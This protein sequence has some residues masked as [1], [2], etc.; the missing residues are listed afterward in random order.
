MIH[1]ALLTDFYA[2]TMAQGYWKNN[3]NKRA[4]FEVFFRRQPFGGGFS[5][6]AGLGPL[7]DTIRDF[8]FSDDDLAYLESLKFFEKPFLNYLRDFHFTGSLWAMDEGTV[9]FPQEPLI[10][11]SGNL[12]ECQIA[13]GMLLNIINF[14]S[15]IATKT[16]R[17]WLA[18]GKGSVM[19]FGLRRAQGP[20]G[21]MSASR[22]AFIGGAAGTS[23]VLAG[24]EY[25]IPVLGTMAHSWIM[26]YPSEEEAFQAYADIYPEF[27][28]FLI[29][30]YDTLKSGT[31][32]AIKV[33][34]RV[35]E[36]GKNFGVRLD[37]GDMHYLSVQVRKLLD[38]A[39]FPN[40]KI[41]VSNDLD[42]S[43]I[44]TLT[45]TGA[46]IDSWGVGTRMVTGG[47]ESAFTG[48]Y[49]LTAREDASGKLIPTIKFSD[50]PEKT[51]NPGLKQVWRLKDSQGMA[52]A[53]IL[54]LEES[55][56][57]PDTLE[58]GSRYIFWHPSADYRHFYHTLEGSAEP[59]LKL[60]LDKGSLVSPQPS[61]EEIRRHT[62]AELELF[63]N[64]YKRLLNPHVY[65]VSVT[66][67]LRQLKLNLIKDYL[68]DL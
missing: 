47:D 39:G 24:K 4:I 7:L 35:V 58:Q 25:G 40:A 68:G 67:K 12:I 32:N 26:A 20:D 53:D 23:N 46:P 50:N 44:E 27:P 56:S 54:G 15:L 51:T 33:G 49:K 28:V 65:K 3:M 9:I 1:S 10:R 34:K 30:T 19:E 57:G 2:L 38:D 43:I 36:R 66:E 5:I 45:N 41:S 62:K 17:V 31:R 52:V 22:A 37:S 42:E 61:L 29:D 6:F 60:R 63:D 13:E 48:V 55:P 14:Q 59:L 8:S 16:A 64:S 18:T 11:L 21:A